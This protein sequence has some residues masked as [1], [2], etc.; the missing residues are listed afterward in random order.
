ME[1]NYIARICKVYYKCR[2]GRLLNYKHGVGAA[3]AVALM[4]I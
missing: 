2:R 4:K 3:E 1:Y